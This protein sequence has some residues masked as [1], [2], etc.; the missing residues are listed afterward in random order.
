MR[1]MLGSVA[2]RGIV[3]TAISIAAISS[4]GCGSGPPPPADREAARDALRSALDAWR[5]GQPSDALSRAQPPIYVSDW[6]W[7]SGAKLLRYE[8]DEHD[9]AIGADRRWPVRLWID[10]GRGKTV[11]E[12]AAYNVGTHPAVTVARAGDR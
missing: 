1:T 8:I 7:R 11:R 4:G 3:A 2:R 12:P 10:N 5:Q 6:R 9:R